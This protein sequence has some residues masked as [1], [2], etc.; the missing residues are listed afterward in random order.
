VSD[1]G[2]AERLEAVCARIVAAARR[3]GRDPAEIVLIGAAKTRSADEVAQAAGA[4][5]T[6]V[7][8]NYVQE[9]RDKRASLAGRE[10]TARLRWHLIG[11]LQRNKARDA[12]R[13]FD[14]IETVD[15]AA[16]AQELERRAAAEKRTL[17]IL[18]QVNV[19]GEPQKSGVAPEDLSDLLAACAALTHLR[20]TGLMTVPA[21]TDDPAAVRP[22]FTRLRTLRDEL[23]GAAGGESLRE[24]SMGMS[25]DF[26]V[27]IEEGATLVRV[28]TALFGPREG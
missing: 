13:T 8:E 7:G 5:L 26:E 1:T 20:V 2:I 27:A 17:E 15:R 12:V 28:G 25:A 18:L 11:H 6:C 3:A 22:A 21:A 16:L 24:L 23:R 10:D 19:S 4:G 14:V 9:A